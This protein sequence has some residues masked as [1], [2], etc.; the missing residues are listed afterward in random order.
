MGKGASVTDTKL[1]RSS[2]ETEAR[3]TRDEEAGI[4]DIVE[5]SHGRLR[6]VEDL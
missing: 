6:I 5:A 1:S 2:D 3:L 4:V